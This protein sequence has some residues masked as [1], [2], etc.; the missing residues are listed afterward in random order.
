MTKAEKYVGE[1]YRAKS[2]KELKG[3]LTEI[4]SDYIERKI[5][6]GLFKALV[7]IISGMLK[8]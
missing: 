6:H 8:D 7:A 4:A 3:I 5:S 1:I 2:K